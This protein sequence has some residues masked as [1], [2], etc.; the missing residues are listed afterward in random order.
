MELE[1]KKLDGSVKSK[2]KLDE[3]VFGIQPNDRVIYD[4]IRTQMAN[5]RQ[6]TAST[7]GRS[8]LKG[9]T[10]K[11]FRQKGTGNARR[12]DIKSPLL[13]GGGTVFG[14]KPRTYRVGINKKAK[15]LARKSALSYKAMEQSIMVVEDFS[16][17]T[18]STKEFLKIVT[19]LQL[20]GKKVAL[21]TSKVE[22]TLKKSA[23]NVTKVFVEEVHSLN[24]YDVV[25]ADV[26]VFQE[27]AVA[28]IQNILNRKFNR[29]VE[30]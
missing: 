14:P 11:L 27:G 4:D 18:F 6:G 7:K 21:Y 5:K 16:F 8:Q 30:A 24:T 12:G 20:Q 10:R 2:I 22:S 19:T 25:N 13:R 15:V 3:S 17:D 29:G 23:A 28:E 9:S 1:V 26:V